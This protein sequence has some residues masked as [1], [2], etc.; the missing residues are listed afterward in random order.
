VHGVG[1]MF[2]FAAVGKAVRPGAGLRP[3]M[4]C[5]EV[6]HVYATEQTLPALK[7]T[8]AP[9]RVL[10]VHSWNGSRWNFPGAHAAMNCSNPVH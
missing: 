6:V 7:P 3:R 8:L 1:E 2:S 5:I 4:D 9:T 10:A